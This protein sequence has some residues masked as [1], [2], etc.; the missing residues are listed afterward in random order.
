[1][2]TDNQFFLLTLIGYFGLLVV[3]H[4]YLGVY[5]ILFGLAVAG[6]RPIYRWLWGFKE[7]GG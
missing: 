4:T 3:L 5:G 6:T 7:I 2:I 1:M